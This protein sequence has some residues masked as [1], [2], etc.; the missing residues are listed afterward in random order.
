MSTSN[1][2]YYSHQVTLQNYIQAH[3]QRNQSKNPKLQLN[4]LLSLAGETEREGN[5]RP[6]DANATTWITDL[7][8][9]H[10]VHKVFV[11]PAR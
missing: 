7:F 11:Q 3:L 2:H 8:F 6:K 1:T 5:Q 10:I 9:S 4:S